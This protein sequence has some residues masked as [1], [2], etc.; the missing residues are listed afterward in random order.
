MKILNFIF[1]GIALI[2]S[3]C[4]NPAREGNALNQNPD[5]LANVQTT[6]GISIK[7]RQHFHT[8]AQRSINSMQ[9][10]IDK[11]DKAMKKRD[12]GLKQKWDGSRDSLRQILDHANRTLNNESYKSDED[13]ENIEKNVGN[14]IDSAQKKMKSGGFVRVDGK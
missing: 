10:I 2:F 11:T 12:N 5:S 8:Q 7:E 14:D 3:S 13:W 1:L 4:S 9:R 6:K